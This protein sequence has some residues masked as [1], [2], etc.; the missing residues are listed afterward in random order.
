MPVSLR[1]I[2]TARNSLI[3][4]SPLYD[5]TREEQAPLRLFA[6]SLFSRPIVQ[7]HL[8]LP[9]SGYVLYHYVL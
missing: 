7:L 1:D 4:K 2:S 9:R 3:S 8:L 6:R 5:F